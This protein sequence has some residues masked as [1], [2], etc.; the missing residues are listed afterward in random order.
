ML[1]DRDI[2]STIE[3]SI[4]TVA[5]HLDYQIDKSDLKKIHASEAT[6]CLRRAY[7]NRTDPLPTPRSRFA[8][9]LGGMFRNLEYGSKSAQFSLDD[10]TLE[11]Q[12][13][14]VVDD[15]IMLFKSVK[16]F[17]DDPF[18]KD[19]L[20]VN[21]CMWIYDKIDGIIIYIDGNGKEV[22]F[23]VT[24]NKKMFEEVVRRVRVLVDL[25]KEKKI[26]ILEPSIECSTCQYY[27]RCFT[28]RK[29]SKTINLMNLL[30]KSKGRSDMIDE[31]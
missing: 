27:E 7:F 31:I 23:S 1:G 12:A 16:K 18:A 22:S 30:G 9:L 26:P 5:N 17:P 28:Q 24:R 25:L 2:R 13:D 14:M 4:D 11:G 15:L 19:I 8:D 20:Y 3:N 6:G 29:E 10:L 21:A